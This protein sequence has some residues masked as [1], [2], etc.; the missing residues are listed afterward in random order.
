MPLAPGSR[1]YILCLDYWGYLGYLGNYGYYSILVNEDGGG[2]SSSIPQTNDYEPDD[3]WEQANQINYN[4]V[5]NYYL[6]P[7][8][9]DW[10]YII[11]P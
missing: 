2:S 8:D 5:Y 4:T 1:Y 3:T 7:D 6:S 10:M 9:Y 11:I